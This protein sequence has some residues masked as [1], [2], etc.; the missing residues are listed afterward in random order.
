MNQE[1]IGQFIL[2]LRKEKNMTQ[3]ELAKR[4][5]VTDRAISHWEKGR[6]LPDVFLLK[7]ICDIFDI[8]INELIRCKKEKESDKMDDDSLFKM[9]D[10]SDTLLKA[11]RKKLNIILLVFGLVII[12]FSFLFFERFFSIVF[13][14]FGN[15]IVSFSLNKLLIK[16]YKKTFSVIFFICVF[17]ICFIFDYLFVVFFRRVPIFYYESK[18]NYEYTEYDSFFYKIYQ[19]NR[20]EGDL[21][22]FIVDTNNKY[23]E[24]NL[25]ISAFNREKNGWDE[26]VFYS[27]MAIDKSQIKNNSF[28]DY[29]A[30]L[31][32]SDC[33]REFH[34]DD[35]TRVTFYCDDLFFLNNTSKYKTAFLYSSLLLFLTRDDVN[36]ITFERFNERFVAYRER[37]QENY[38]NYK[39]INE[40]NFNQLVERKM[41]NTYFIN[42]VFDNVFV[43]DYKGE[44]FI[45]TYKVL[46]IDDGP[47]INS[48]FLTLNQC[49]G[50]EETVL[51]KEIDRVPEA[52]KVY[53]FTI[54]PKVSTNYIDDTIDSIF[55][56]SMVLNIV[57][58][59]KICEEQTQGKINR[60]VL[61]K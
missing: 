19:V 37:F 53:E 15:L 25:P 1:E 29:T 24:D 3:E 36:K 4:L 52:G 7:E 38:P 9:I 34:I 61:K 12:I 30:F 45:R 31:P 39:E 51:V 46:N 28:N 49:D 42:K 35:Q 20:G 13:I 17:I 43:G 23:N 21:E 57:E 18:V 33:S 40:G 10:Y 58:T 5:H 2:K 32:L 47:V 27:K 22:Y 14:I 26:A 8:S 55:D 50:E 44:T 11:N 41:F 56:N 54:Q 48:Y 60:Y 16:K 6:R 59:D